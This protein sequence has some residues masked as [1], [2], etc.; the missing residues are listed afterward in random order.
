MKIIR[1]QTADEIE[2]VRA[3][4][5]DYQRFF[6][7]GSLFLGFRGEAGHTAG[8]LCT[9]RESGCC[10]HLVDS[11]PRDAQRCSL[12]INVS[13]KW[14]RLFVRLG[15]RG[16]GLATPWQGA[17]RKR[18]GEPRGGY[19]RYAVGYLLTGLESAKQTYDVMG[20]QCRVLCYANPLLGWCIG[21]ETCETPVCLSLPVG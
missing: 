18:S 5:R 9:A 7:R 1:A 15:S 19:V 2:A 14:K 21:S 10:W 20:F 13:V 16:Q 3:L 12:W 8:T 17:S 11:T 6:G 4:F